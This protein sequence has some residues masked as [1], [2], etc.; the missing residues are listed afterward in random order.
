[1]GGGGES[2]FAEQ[3]RVCVCW[4]G[5]VCLLGGGGGGGVFS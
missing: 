1:M 4:K 5:C 2:V 3:M